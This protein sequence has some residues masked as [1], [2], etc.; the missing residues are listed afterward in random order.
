MGE[1][2]SSFSNQM[3][4]T[5]CEFSPTSNLLRIIQFCHNLEKILHSKA[6]NDITLSVARTE[7]MNRKAGSVIIARRYKKALWF[8]NSQ[9][10]VE[11]HKFRIQ[12]IMWFLLTGDGGPS[13]S[14]GGDTC[15]LMDFKI[16]KKVISYGALHKQ[17]YT[18][19]PLY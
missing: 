9:T 10:V 12:I 2:A 1:T 15:V 17:V 11:L 6:A 5:K 7:C 4:N 8:K 14:V 13:C 19:Q 16:K 3:F 18:H